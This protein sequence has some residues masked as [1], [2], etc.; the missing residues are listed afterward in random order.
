MTGYSA[1]KGTGSAKTMAKQGKVTKDNPDT[2]F[3]ESLTPDSEGEKKVTE[4][5]ANTSKK[6][7]DAYDAFVAKMNEYKKSGGT[8]NKEQAGKVNAKNK[9][10]LDKANFDINAQNFTTDSI[11]NVHN[12]YNEAVAVNNA[13]VKKDKENKKKND[14]KFNTLIND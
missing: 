10:I 6:S 2:D 8:L 14:D 5:R 4:K 1:G 9:T 3:D 13:K 11:S 12:K 7:G